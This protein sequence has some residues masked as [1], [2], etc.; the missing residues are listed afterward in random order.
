MDHDNRA[1]SL[2]QFFKKEVGIMFSS[3]ASQSGVMRHLCMQ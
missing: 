3:S 2:C 1:K